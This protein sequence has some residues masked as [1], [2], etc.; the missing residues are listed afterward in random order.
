MNIKF[1]GKS[2]YNISNIFKYDPFALIIHEDSSKSLIFNNFE[3]ARFWYRNGYIIEN[4][5]K[6]IIVKK[7]I[8]DVDFDSELEMFCVF[9]DNESSLEILC[10]ILKKKILKNGGKNEQNKN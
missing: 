5:A 6:K 10:D 9:S 7:D 4:V 1:K 2:V 3:L 8:K